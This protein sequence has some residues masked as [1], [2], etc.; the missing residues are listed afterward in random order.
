M[1]TQTKLI[2]FFTAILFVLLFVWGSIAYVFFAGN[3]WKNSVRTD[4]IELGQYMEFLK[5]KSANIENYA[6]KLVINERLQAFLKNVEMLERSSEKNSYISGFFREFSDEIS[7]DTAVQSMVMVSAAGN[8]YWSQYPYTNEFSSYWEEI[9]AGREKESSFYSMPYVIFSGFTRY[10][11]VSYAIEVRDLEELSRSI[12]YLVINIHFGNWGG[13]CQ[14]M[15][16]YYDSVCWNVCDDTWYHSASDGGKK[17]ADNNGKKPGE[18]NGCEIEEYSDKS[19]LL[20]LADTD[21]DWSLSVYRKYANIVDV[22]KY[23]MIFAAFFLTGGA[24]I[25][26]LLLLLSDRLYTKPIQKLVGDMEEIKEGN[27]DYEY[28]PA[29]A[30]DMKYLGD[31]LRQMASQLKVLVERRV[32]DEKNIRNLELEVL[33]LQINP[34]FIYNTLNTVIYIARKEKCPSIEQLMKSFIVLLKDVLPSADEQGAFVTVE[35]ELHIVGHYCVVQNFR[36]PDMI[37]LRTEVSPRVLP[38]YIP[39]AI[40]QPLVENA[41]LHGIFPTEKKGHICI[42]ADREEDELIIQVENDG[43]SIEEEMIER[44]YNNEPLLKTDGRVRSIGIENVRQRLSLYY[45]KYYF[46]IERIADGGTR[47]LM[48]L[49]RK[50]EKTYFREQ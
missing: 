46:S 7:I 26:L 27:F 41:I 17:N 44:I 14:R 40:L 21:R 18:E 35:R 15:E 34:H 29:Y 31:N 1:K 39:K 6:A 8:T 49:P 50:P 4:T 2:S 5:E 38:E 30:A 33:L 42:K 22:K 12:G 23:I 28:E 3:T 25:V 10:N 36:Y 11:V 24:A 16:D 9:S 32:E 20:T 37:G 13:I 19:Y 48:R 47:V 45:R 43:I